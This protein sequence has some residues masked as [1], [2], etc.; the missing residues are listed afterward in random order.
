MK[1]IKYLIKIFIMRDHLSHSTPPPTCLGRSGRH[2]K[3]VVF[4]VYS[5]QKL[6]ALCGYYF[7]VFSSGIVREG[8]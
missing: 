3:L 4:S 2:H 8:E 6:D 1:T 5:Q 7:R